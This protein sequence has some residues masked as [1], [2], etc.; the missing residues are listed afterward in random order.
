MRFIFIFIDGVGIGI[1]NGNNPFVYADPGILKLWEGS[2]Y[3]NNSI[4]LKAI[5]PLLGIPGIPQSATGQTTIFTGINIP[6]LLSKHIGSFPNKLM[7][8]VIKEENLLLKLDNSGKKV[9]FVNA[10]PHHSEIFSNSHIKI[11]KEG[12]LIFSDEFPEKFKKR[13]SVTSSILISNNMTP[14]DTK[15]I[16]EKRSLYQD[17]SNK[18]LLRYGLDLPVFTPEDAA[19]V[20]H[21]ASTDYDLILYEF[22]QSD[23]YG[24]RKNITEQVELI[25]GLDILLSSLISLLDPEEDTLLITSDHGNL[26]DSSGKSHTLNPVP[27]ITW[28]RGSSELSKNIDDL[29][30]IT[31]EILN[32]LTS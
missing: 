17:Y 22:F 26:E 29:S 18:S 32:F 11:D 7:R 20:L 5:D 10:Y 4:S 3:D 21:N 15:D 13:I 16:K 30:D 31:P 1:S 12:N 23:I 28:G 14:F 6:M 27:L 8:K 19:G 9:K 25:S 2:V 24:H